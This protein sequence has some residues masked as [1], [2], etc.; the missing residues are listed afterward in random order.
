MNNKIRFALTLTSTCL[1]KSLSPIETPPVVTI[2]SP[3]FKARVILVFKSSKSSV[4]IPQSK[5]GKPCSLLIKVI[6]VLLLL[7]L[8][9]PARRA[10]KFLKGLSKKKKTCE[11]FFSFSSGKNVKKNSVK[12]SLIFKKILAHCAWFQVA[13]ILR[14]L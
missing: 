3:L 9:Y 1:N 10:R 11:I 13:A 6:K 7:S 4:A 2:K 8:M 5:M 12:L 14:I